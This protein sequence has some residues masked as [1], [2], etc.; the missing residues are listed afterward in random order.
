MV[1]LE[2]LVAVVEMMRAKGVRELRWD[3]MHIVLGPSAPTI[4]A[5][6][7]T[8]RDVS[9]PSKTYEDRI[10]E[11]AEF[12]HFEQFGTLPMGK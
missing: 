1:N 7:P 10:D 2:K 3:E 8:E 9:G 4:P 11:D 6:P 12:Q 5:P